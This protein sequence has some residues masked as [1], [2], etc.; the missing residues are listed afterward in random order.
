MQPHQ[1]AQ[2]YAFARARI[3]DQRHSLATADFQVHAIKR[4]HGL[5]AGLESDFQ[6][7]DTDKRLRGGRHA[8]APEAA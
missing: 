1:R 6:V 8:S 7:A 3:A 5:R 4:M 2:R